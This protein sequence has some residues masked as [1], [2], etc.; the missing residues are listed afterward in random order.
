MAC[1]WIV[2]NLWI[3]VNMIMARG[4]KARKLENSTTLNMKQQLSNGKSM[5][6]H[7]IRLHGLFEGINCNNVSLSL[8]RSGCEC[9]QESLFVWLVWNQLRCTDAG[10]VQE[11]K[12]TEF[13]LMVVIHG[14]SALM[15]H[16]CKP[17]SFIAS[18]LCGIHIEITEHQTYGIET[19]ANR[20][21]GFSVWKLL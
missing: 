21:F 11:R 12:H 15:F 5:S 7:R 18:N 20:S 14:F 10:G 2:I 19:T 9:M 1:S 13:H 16:C 3:L 6:V 4:L 8:Y 17:S